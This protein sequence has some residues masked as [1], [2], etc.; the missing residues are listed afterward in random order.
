MES[1]Y[2]G[3]TLADCLGLVSNSTV[4]YEECAEILEEKLQH[5]FP[6]IK[7]DEFYPLIK[8]KS[9]DQ[10][11]YCYRLIKAGKQLEEMSRN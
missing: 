11:D 4:T 1:R 8:K 3:Y 2:D 10:E 9:F 6:W 7:P 5:S